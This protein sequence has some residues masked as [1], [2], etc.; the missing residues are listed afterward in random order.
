MWWWRHLSAWVKWK[1]SLNAS[2]LNQ[3]FNHGCCYQKIVNQIAIEHDHNYKY[4]QYSWWRTHATK[5][6]S[7]HDSDYLV[8]NI[9]LLDIFRFKYFH[10]FSL[11]AKYFHDART[12]PTDYSNKLPAENRTALIQTSFRFQSG[13]SSS[14]YISILLLMHGAP[15]EP[16]NLDKIWSP[17]FLAT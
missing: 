4:W 6:P 14:Y 1:F 17:V 16:H 7:P 10:Y 12:Q 13:H 11:V 15:R 9:L 5:N 3:P 8:L 2:K